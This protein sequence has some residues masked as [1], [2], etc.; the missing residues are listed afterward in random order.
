MSIIT[1]ALRLWQLGSLCSRRLSYGIRPLSQKK[2]KKG[3]VFCNPLSGI[4]AFCLAG[5]EE[6][7]QDSDFLLGLPLTRWFQGWALLSLGHGE[8]TH[9]SYL[10]SMAGF[11][12][13]FFLLP[14]FHQRKCKSL[15]P[16]VCLG[17]LVSEANSVGLQAQSLNGF[18]FCLFIITSSFQKLL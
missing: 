1:A 4:L 13:L 15:V 5:F 7:V 12:F 17:L 2:K 14:L 3:E 10:L 6:Q 11:S 16:E 9:F 8:G 18:H